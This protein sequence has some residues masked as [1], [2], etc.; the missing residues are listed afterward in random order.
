[1]IAI[2]ADETRDPDAPVAA[3]AEIHLLPAIAGG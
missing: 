2:G 3:D 1:M